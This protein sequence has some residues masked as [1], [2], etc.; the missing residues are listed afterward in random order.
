MPRFIARTIHSYLDYPV[1][2]GLLIMPTLLGLG[3]SIP[4]AFWL[5]VITG[6]AALGLTLVTDHQTGVIR[7]LPYSLHLAVDFLVGATF[8]VGTVRARFCRSRCP[9]LLGGRSHGPGC[10]RFAQTRRHTSAHNKLSVS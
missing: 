8:I 5:S 3:L 10:R 6:L 9:I 1:A 7:V 2:L 4:L